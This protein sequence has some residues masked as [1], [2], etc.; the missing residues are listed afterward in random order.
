VKKFLLLLALIVPAIHLV[1]TAAQDHAR[2]VITRQNADQVELLHVIGRGRLFDVD[3]SSDGEHIAVFSENTVTVHDADTLSAEQVLQMEPCGPGYA[4]RGT[5]DFAEDSQ[6]LIVGGGTRIATYDGDFSP[7]AVYEDDLD[8]SILFYSQPNKL[9]VY[10][11]GGPESGQGVVYQSFEPSS[12]SDQNLFFNTPAMVLEDG[13]PAGFSVSPDGQLLAINYGQLVMRDDWHY[14]GA[15]YTVVYDLPSI[16]KLIENDEIDTFDTQ[17]FIENERFRIELEGQSD[18]LTHVTFSPDGTLLAGAGQDGR[19]HLWSMP[20]GAEVAVYDTHYT[21]AW[22]IAFSPDGTQLVSAGGDGTIRFWDVA[23][24]EETLLISGLQMAISTIS[25]N[26]DG[27]HLVAGGWD[28][29]LWIFDTT[30]GEIIDEYKPYSLPAWTIAFSPDGTQFAIGTDGSDVVLFDVIDEPPFIVE[31]YIFREH[32]GPVYALAFDP[33]GPF[34]AS[35]GSDGIIY[36]WHTGTGKKAKTI[37]TYPYTSVFSLAYNPHNSTLYCGT[38]SGIGD[39][40][41]S[42]AG[43]SRC[44]IFLG[45]KD[46]I[47]TMAF[48]PHQ[49]LL[50][51]GATVIAEL[52]NRS[53]V[54]FGSWSSYEESPVQRRTKL[55]FSADGSVLLNAGSVAH[56][57]RLDDMVNKTLI[58]PYDLL[59]LSPDGSLVAGNNFAI[60]DSV[61]GE[62]IHRVEPIYNQTHIDRWLH[63]AVFSPDGTLIVTSSVGGALR[64]WGV[65]GN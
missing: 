25:Y 32:K 21:A 13:I 36:L 56:V 58:T 49:N 42:Q 57:R 18:A 37:E 16:F 39:V 52:D 59:A 6:T 26:P 15:S 34:L 2:P 11:G 65:P 45:S 40:D 48:H 55:T 60:F 27:S 12:I 33:D 29:S 30:T 46:P 23:T 8:K 22:D 63:D 24:G 54:D 20:D 41:N 61:T 47:Y 28:G 17:N 3:W 19:V 38:N 4:C 5:V 1:D 9:L 10:G 53:S 43:G 64:F 62:E 7:I 35:G 50:A 51:Y 31:K 44:F 14:Q